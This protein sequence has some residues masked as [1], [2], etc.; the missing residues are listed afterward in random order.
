MLLHESTRFAFAIFRK[1][2]KQSRLLTVL[3]S[4]DKVVKSMVDDP[5]YMTMF[6]EHFQFQAGFFVM[7]FILLNYHT[8]H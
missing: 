3:L 2:R 5:G 8:C 1:Q 7:I 4:S 6:D